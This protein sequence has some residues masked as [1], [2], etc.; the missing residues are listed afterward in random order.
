MTAQIIP[1]PKRDAF[2]TEM[3]EIKAC[4]VKSYAQLTGNLLPDDSAEMIARAIL[5]APQIDGFKS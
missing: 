2:K 1:F 3:D 4:A 5:D